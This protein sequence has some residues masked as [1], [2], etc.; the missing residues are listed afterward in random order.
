MTWKR[1]LW[2]A[3][4]AQ[5]LSMSAFSFVLPFIPLYLQQL[6]VR[7][8]GDAAAWGG[9]IAAS[10]AFALALAQPFWG[11]LSDRHG[12]KP[13][14]VRSM[15][16]ASLTMVL[17]GLATSPLL[18]LVF[19][20]V[21]GLV[22]GTVTASNTLVSATV[23]REKVGG[24]LGLMQV[25][26]HLG[27]S[28]GPLLGGVISDAFGYRV[29][30]FVA[31]GLTAAGGSLVSLLVRED[32]TPPPGGASQ[33]V[34]AG[35]RAVLAVHGMAA[36]LGVVFLIQY[37]NSGVAPILSLYVQVLAGE[38]PAATTAGVILAATGAVGALSAVI[39]GR[40]GDRIDPRKILVV[41]LLGA[42][43]TCLPQ[44]SVDHPWELL[45]WRMGLG[46]FLGGLM[47][48][49]NATLS[50]IVPEE[51]RGQAFGIAATTNA[52][53]NGAGPLSGAAVVNHFGL[54]SAFLLAASLYGAGFLLAL[55]GFLLRRG[56]TR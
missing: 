45:A 3:W 47:P 52:L 54:S 29:S 51:R 53:A 40:L 42:A 38:G 20:F 56:L 43:M 41:C 2:V 34:L 48:T 10:A 25:A 23:P 16:G 19:R 14:V 30:F 26:L 6:G 35:S 50:R 1:T 31:A 9:A 8:T 36:V 4:C 12:R 18:L 22:T 17:M 46:V 44:A 33:G 39:V 21:Q 24:A 32:F 7:D 15:W 55:R 11:N 5:F 27:L 37:G 13:M 49:A 28:L